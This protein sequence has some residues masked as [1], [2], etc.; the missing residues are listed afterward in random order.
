MVAPRV[1][2]ILVALGVLIAPLAKAAEEDSVRETFYAYKT[3]IMNEDGRAGAA[4]IAQPTV[5]YYEVMRGLALSAPADR[6]RQESTVN[7]MMALFMRHRVPTSDLQSMSGVALLE[8]AI[9]HGWIGKNSVAPLEVE[10]VYV[11][12]RTAIADV[13]SLRDSAKG[14]F[15]F[16]KENG[17]WRVDLILVMQTGSLALDVMAEEQA[18][19]REELILGLLSAVS[20]KRVDE[21]IWDP[22]LASDD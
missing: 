4:L 9:N 18:M 16:Y 1:V 7:L 5:D 15:R 21:S 6:L 8:Y 3:A 11:V 22:P 19:T 20:G 2:S 17:G 13:V 12:G 14:Q 10:V